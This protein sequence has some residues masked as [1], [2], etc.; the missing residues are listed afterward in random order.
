M[1]GIVHYEA[2][3]LTAIMLNLIPGTDTMYIISRSISQGRQA[4]ILSVLG[5]LTGSLIHTVLAAFGLSLILAQSVVLFNI[6]K[7]LGVAYLVYLGVRMFMTKEALSF[8]STASP[9]RKAGKV[10]GQAIVTSVTNPKVA[11][12]FIAFLPQFVDATH[13]GPLPFLLLGLTF[14]LTGGIWFSLV[15]LFA[16]FVT[17]KMRNNP[18]FSSILNKLT[19]IVFIGMGLNLLRAKATP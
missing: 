2:F 4:G 15:A 5:I 14:T 12:F 9:G 10:Y 16:S 19:G 18:H 7:I 8:D 17:Q 3:V 6:V 13:T 1:F 11:L